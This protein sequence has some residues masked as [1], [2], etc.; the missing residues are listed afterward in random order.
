MIR[1]IIKPE[2]SPN[3][4]IEDIHKIR[5]W[6]YEKLKNATTEERRNYYRKSAIAI[7]KEIEA[8]K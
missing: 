3:F 5:E 2:L 7:Q 4:T 8:Q 6:H 1:E